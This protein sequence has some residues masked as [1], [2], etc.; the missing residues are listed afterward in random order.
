MDHM[1]APPSPP[2]LQPSAKRW[3]LKGPGLKLEQ[4]ESTVTRRKKNTQSLLVE[5][6]H[7]WRFLLHFLK[8]NFFPK[9][10]TWH[11]CCRLV[12][13]TFWIRCFVRSHKPGRATLFFEGLAS[14]SLCL[15]KSCLES[16]I[17]G[18]T[19]PKKSMVKG[20][21]RTLTL[22][23]PSNMVECLAHTAKKWTHTHP[24]ATWGK[25]VSYTQNIA[26]N[27]YLENWP[28]SFLFKPHNCGWCVKDHLLEI[29]STL[30][31]RYM[32][33]PKHIPI[34]LDIHIQIHINTYTYKYICNCEYTFTYR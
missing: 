25:G 5:L 18:T 10:W 19:P 11:F 12:E 1:D 31:S 17:F 4:R 33:I 6:W 15:W 22:N 32:K 2:Y 13:A 9:S 27:L 34:H 24:H 21:E 16:H 23:C 20:S 28:S 8:A 7:V 14:R 29:D 30:F 3:P 26:K